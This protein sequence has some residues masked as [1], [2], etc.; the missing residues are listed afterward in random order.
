MEELFYKY[1]VDIYFTGHIHSYERTWPTFQGNV[2]STNPDT[3]YINPLSTIYLIIGGAGND[4]MEDAT[5]PEL[6]GMDDPD[7][8]LSYKKHSNDD[9]GPWSASVDLHHFGIGKVTVINATTLKFDYI[10]TSIEQI[11]DSI[12]IQ[13]N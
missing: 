9:Y 6:N 11:Y 13:K 12:I 1:N 8:S 5:I 2:L 4:E 7:E 10:Q 3:A